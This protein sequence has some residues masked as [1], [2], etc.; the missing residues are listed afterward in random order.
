MQ[1]QNAVALVTG[2]NGGIGKHYI[3]TLLTLGAARIYAGA[4]KISSLDDL[5]ALNPDRIIP[6]ALDI[7]D[8]STVAAAVAQCSDVNLL[9]NNAGIG[10]LKGFISAPDLAA[11]RAEMEVN[12]FGTLTM[13]RGFAPVLKANG[14][15]AIVNMLSILGRVNFPMNASYS[16]SKGAGYILTQGVRA[17]L[18]AQ[19]TLVVGVMPATVDTKGSQDFPPPKVAPVTVAQE[20][21][22]AVIDGVEDVYPGEQAKAI[23][24]QLL[25]DPK[26]LEKA[27]AAMLPQSA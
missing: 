16:A 17:E 12:Y 1:V 25:S 13:C 2:A 9:I 8:H 7:T 18:A 15:G 23:A 26:G 19:N 10:L 22:Q 11:A 5:V 14:G 27:M 20:A 3:E 21:L 4:R 24:A 6:V